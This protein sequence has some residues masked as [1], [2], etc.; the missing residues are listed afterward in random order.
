M[1]FANP[2]PVGEIV[3]VTGVGWPGVTSTVVPGPTMLKSSTT[4]LLGPD[5]PPPGDGF[6]TV[7][8]TAPPVATSVAGIAAVSWP[9]FRKV[10]VSAFPLKFTVELDTKLE[11][12]T[13]SVNAA[14]AAECPGETPLVNGAGLLTV[15]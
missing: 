13:V 9:E 3:M 2:S 4:K 8:L 6:A 14:P 7:T 10:V 5:V 15:S 11:P 12:F 1:A